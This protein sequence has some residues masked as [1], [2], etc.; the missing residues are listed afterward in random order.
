VSRRFAFLRG[1][2]VGGHRLAMERLRELFREIGF[3]GV[4]TFI[5]SGNVIFDAGEEEEDAPLEERVEAHLASA[6]GY[7]V[8]TFVR[9]PAELAR[10]AGFRPFD[11]ADDDPHTLHVAFLKGGDHAPLAAAL[12]ALRTPTDDFRVHGR[13]AYWLCRTRMSD[14][15]VG[16]AVTKALSRA[17]LRNSSTLRRLLA[18][19]PAG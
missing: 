12:G 15:P 9:S 8:D 5:A 1:M 6:L 7:R 19:Y 18:R 3:G 14:S 2:N 10:V 13:E 11:V 17:T 4:E 16:N